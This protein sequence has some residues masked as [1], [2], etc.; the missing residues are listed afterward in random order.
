MTL[1]RREV[2]VGMLPTTSSSFISIRNAQGHGSLQLSV[3]NVNIALYVY[4]PVCSVAAEVATFLRNHGAF[5]QMIPAKDVASHRRQ[6]QSR[7]THQ[8]SGDDEG[9]WTCPY[10]WR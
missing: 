2:F 3:K 6:N 9:L 4:T 8:H 10:K 1:Y 7:Q 5:F